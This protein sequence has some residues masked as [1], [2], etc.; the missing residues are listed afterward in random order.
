MTGTSDVKGVSSFFLLL[1]LAFLFCYLAVAFLIHSKGI[2]TGVQLRESGSIRT[3]P[4]CQLEIQPCVVRSKSLLHTDQSKSEKNK[5]K[6]RNQQV[7]DTGQCSGWK[8][9]LLPYTH[10]T[11]SPPFNHFLHH[12]AIKT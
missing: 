8:P 5:Q 6:T 11:L 10:L 1:L 9:A 7:T 3:F 4:A 2:H 12:K